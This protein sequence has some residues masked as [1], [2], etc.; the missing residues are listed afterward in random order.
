MLVLII[1]PLEPRSDLPPLCSEDGHSKY[2]EC[3]TQLFQLQPIWDK[4]YLVREVMHHFPNESFSTIQAETTFVIPYVSYAITDGPFRSSWVRFGYDPSKSPQAWMY[5]YIEF[6]FSKRPKLKEEA[7]RSR[8]L[9]VLYD[10]ELN[11]HN[12]YPLYG[13]RVIEV[14]RNNE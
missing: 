10:M 2:S 4:R 5:Q 11:L 3:L 6:R 9:P 13:V 12:R 14:K 1:V 7:P 8:S